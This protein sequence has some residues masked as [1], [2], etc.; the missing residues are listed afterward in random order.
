MTIELKPTDGWKSFDLH[1]DVSDFIY[2]QYDEILKFAGWKYVNI[3]SDTALFES[4][5]GNTVYLEFSPSDSDNYDRIQKMLFEYS[6]SSDSLILHLEQ[7][8]T[9]KFQLKRIVKK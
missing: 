9:T 7:E 4:P 5:M 3:T 1:L 2:A 8:L 6:N